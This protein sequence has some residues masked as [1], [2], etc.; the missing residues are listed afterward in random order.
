[1]HAYYLAF[2]FEVEVT[3]KF[4]GTKETQ[5]SAISTKSRPSSCSSQPVSRSAPARSMLM[6]QAP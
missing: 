5:A 3:D 6:D 1:M 4:G 2:D